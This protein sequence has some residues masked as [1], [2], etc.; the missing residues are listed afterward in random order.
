MRREGDRLHLSS[1]VL[2]GSVLDGTPS[3][4]PGWSLTPEKEGPLVGVPNAAG[5]TVTPTT[6]VIAV[7]ADMLAT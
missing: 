2:S 7:N 5:I 1:Q 6:G 3:P 4:G